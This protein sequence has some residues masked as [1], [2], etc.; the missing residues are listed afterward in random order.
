MR[1]GKEFDWG[2]GERERERVIEGKVKFPFLVSHG[3][4][5]TRI[6][7]KAV[8]GISVVFKLFRS[9]QHHVQYSPSNKKENPHR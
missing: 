9:K 1:E 4:E 8:G 6:S 5:L 7:L 2:V 3:V